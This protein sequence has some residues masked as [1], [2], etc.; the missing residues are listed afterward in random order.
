LP[1]CGCRPSKSLRSQAFSSALAGMGWGGLSG[2]PVSVCDAN[3]GVNGRSSLRCDTPTTSW[4]GAGL[5][6]KQEVCPGEV[7][8]GLS[9]GLF[10]S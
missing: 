1:R 7:C 2:T 3:S 6:S 9:M 8:L 5:L 4:Q 10:Q